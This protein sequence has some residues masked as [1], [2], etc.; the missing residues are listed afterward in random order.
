M[1]CTPV[2]EALQWLDPQNLL[3]CIQQSL[4]AA[5]LYHNHM[6][7]LYDVQTELE[8]LAAHLAAQHASPEEVKVL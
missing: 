5:S 1:S 2:R 3:T 7:K 4:I 6:A 8:G